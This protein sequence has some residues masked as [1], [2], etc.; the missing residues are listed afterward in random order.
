MG[1]TPFTVLQENNSQAA[2]DLGLIP[3]GQSVSLAATASGGSEIITGSDANPG[4]T[5]SVFNALVRLAAALRGDDQPSINRAV[6][7]IDSSTKQLNFSQAEVGARQQAVD[8]LQA[9]A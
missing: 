6:G 3:A 7:L 2:Q 5:G 9:Q 4:E 1:A 8:T